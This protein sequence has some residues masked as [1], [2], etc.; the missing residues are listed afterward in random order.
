MLTAELV[1]KESKETIKKICDYLMEDEIVIIGI[2]GMG[3]VGKTAILM[4]VHNKVLENPTFNDVFWL[5]V[6]QEF[7]FDE[8]Q[9]KIANVVRLDN[10]SKDK[11]VKRRVCILDRHMMK[12]K[13]CVKWH[14]DALRG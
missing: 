9:D 4:H 3:G 14:V 6:P 2:Y 13:R 11:D 1:D 5:T 7:S 12:K 8:L 10:L